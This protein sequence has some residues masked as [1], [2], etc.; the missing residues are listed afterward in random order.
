MLGH[1]AYPRG[2]LIG[3]RHAAHHS[4]SGSMLLA[5]TSCLAH[6]QLQCLPMNAGSRPLL[7]QLVHSRG[8]PMTKQVCDV[9]SDLLISPFESHNSQSTCKPLERLKAEVVQKVAVLRYH[10]W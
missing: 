7:N 2:F 8:A 10:T 5:M 6:V 1:W 4:D 9:G 3:Q